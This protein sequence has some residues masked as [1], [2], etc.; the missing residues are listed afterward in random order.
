MYIEDKIWDEHV[1]EMCQALD[2]L[3]SLKNS[4]M[5]DPLSDEGRYVK[6]LTGL[7]TSLLNLADQ[8]IP[9]EKRKE[10]N[11]RQKLIDNRNKFRRMV[12][13]HL[14]RYAKRQLLKEKYISCIK[15]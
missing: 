12:L 1:S 14:S 13:K 7:F 4:L 9:P 8:H 10:A 3:D 2:C 6:A 11:R 15:S 5:L